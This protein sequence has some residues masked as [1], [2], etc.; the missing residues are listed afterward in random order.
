[1]GLS[2]AASAV[3]LRVCCVFGFR[4]TAIMFLSQKTHHTTYPGET[5][6]AKKGPFWMRRGLFKSEV[7][8]SHLPEVNSALRRLSLL[9]GIG[10]LRSALR[11]SR[12]SR[13]HRAGP[14]ASLDKSIT[15][16]SLE[17]I[18]TQSECGCQVSVA[19]AFRPI[20]RSP[21]STA[22]R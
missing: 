6:G 22:P 10:T 18:L 14:S 19:E 3:L 16:F 11:S 20:A 12:L 21:R 5:R 4:S 7:P 17:P 13:H 9:A 2:S 1:M 8:D 15:L